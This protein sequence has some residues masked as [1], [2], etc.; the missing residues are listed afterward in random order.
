MRRHIRNGILYFKH[1]V[2]QQT[3]SWIS[4]FFTVAAG[5]G[6]SLQL[7]RF[8]GTECT[9]APALPGGQ[10]A[11]PHLGTS[12]R[13]NPESA[14][15]IQG[16]QSSLKALV[17]GAAHSSEILSSRVWIVLL[18]ERLEQPSPACVVSP[19]FT[20]LL[21]APRHESA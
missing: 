21:A 8:H 11:S 19:T 3:E 7:R 20:S 9:I 12:S 5:R 15:G 16:A 13:S 14:L 6:K 2:K 17:G 10:R 1:K 4:P 18:W